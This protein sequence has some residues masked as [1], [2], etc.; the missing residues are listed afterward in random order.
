[1]ISTVTLYIWSSVDLEEIQRHLAS[2]NIAVFLVDWSL[3]NC[4]WC[5]GQKVR[6]NTGGSGT[7][8]ITVHGS[9]DRRYSHYVCLSWTFGFL[10]EQSA[11]EN[12]PWFPRSW[13]ILEFETILE[14]HG[15]VMDFSLFPKKSWKTDIS[16]K[17][18]WKSHGILHRPSVP[19]MICGCGSL[20][21][22]IYKFTVTVSYTQYILI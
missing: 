15:K 14:S 9:F 4:K 11:L 17:R 5:S 19:C 12:V 1:M 22:F 20:L 8:D 10:E 18:L 7:G 6:S 16:R 13:K 2:G 21:I 3:L